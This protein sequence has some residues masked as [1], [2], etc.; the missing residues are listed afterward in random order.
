MTRDLLEGLKNLGKIKVFASW[1]YLGPSW[2]YLGTS[3][4]IL[5][6][7]TSNLGVSWPIMG[8][9]MASWSHLGTI[10]GPFWAFSGGAGPPKTLIFPRFFKGFCNLAIF[11]SI[12]TVLPYLAPSCLPL[13]LSWGHLGAHLDPLGSIL[14]L[15]WAIFGPPWALLGPPWG[16]LGAILAHLGAILGHLGAALEP[17]WAMACPS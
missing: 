16:H 10:L 15:S 2:G 6:Q 5:P 17:S 14:G 11:P 7:L 1:G 8:H 9:L 13:G 3:W 12:S 4:P